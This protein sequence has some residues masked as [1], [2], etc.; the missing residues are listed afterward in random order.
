M[1]HE[2]NKMRIAAIDLFYEL[3]PFAEQTGH[4]GCPGWSSESK[5]PNENQMLIDEIICTL[6]EIQKHAK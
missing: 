3:V 6:K 2:L 5:P 4:P 1:N